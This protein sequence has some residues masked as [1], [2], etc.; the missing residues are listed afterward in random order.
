[1][2]SRALSDA[3]HAAV[4]RNVGARAICSYDGRLDVVSG[5]TRLEPDAV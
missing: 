4:C 1:M 5:L 2:G 3:L